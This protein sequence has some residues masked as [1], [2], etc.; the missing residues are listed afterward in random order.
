MAESSLTGRLLQI[1]LIV[2]QVRCYRHRGSSQGGPANL[3]GDKH[4]RL[5]FGR[6]LRLVVR[7]GAARFS[8]AGVQ[9]IS[10]VIAKIPEKEME[11]GDPLFHTYA[12]VPATAQMSVVV[13]SLFWEFVQSAPTDQ[14]LRTAE[15]FLEAVQ[16][17]VEDLRNKLIPPIASDESTDESTP[18]LPDCNK[19]VP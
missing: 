4:D 11:K 12:S 18:R 9:S 19:P 3:Y 2:E 17:E 6:T 5:T 8:G 7:L 14:Q 10:K 13:R 16:A 1:G 15:L